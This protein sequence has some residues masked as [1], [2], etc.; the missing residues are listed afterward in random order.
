MAE[1]QTADRWVICSTTNT[2]ASA[3]TITLAPVGG[4]GCSSCHAVFAAVYFF[5]FHIGKAGITVEE[6]HENARGRQ[7]PAAIRRDRRA[8]A[9]RAT[10]IKYMQ[11]PEWLQVGR[12]VYEQRCKSCHGEGGEDWWARI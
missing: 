1:N 5:Y 3:S 11:E 8:E 4:D 12:S 9:G 6:D 7:C 2:M 10:L